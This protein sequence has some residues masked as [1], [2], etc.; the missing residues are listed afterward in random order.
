MAIRRASQE[1]MNAEE[2]VAMTKVSSK[3][4]ESGQ[5]Q[6]IERKLVAPAVHLATRTSPAKAAPEPARTKKS[7]KKQAKKPAA[8]EASEEDMTPYFHG[9]IPKKDAETLLLANG[10]GEVTGRYLIRAKGDGKKEFILSVVYKGKPTHHNVS[11]LASGN[12]SINKKESKAKTLAALTKILAKKNKALGWPVPLTEGVNGPK[13]AKKPSKGAKAFAVIDID[14]DGNLQL[15]EMLQ[16]G[17]SEKTFRLIDT[18]GSGTIEK[19]EFRKWYKA[20]PAEA[21][22]LMKSGAVKHL[23]SS[24]FEAQEELT[25]T[26]KKSFI[27]TTRAPSTL[28]PNFDTDAQELQRTM[29]NQTEAFDVRKTWSNVLNSASSGIPTVG[30]DAQDI[31]RSKHASARSFEAKKQWSNVLY[32]T[33]GETP[34]IDTTAMDFQ[35]AQGSQRDTADYRRVNVQIARGSSVARS[36]G[37]DVHH[38]TAAEPPIDLLIP[39]DSGIMEAQKAKFT[40]AGQTYVKPDSALPPPAVSL[41]ERVASLNFGDT[42]AAGGSVLA[43]RQ[44]PPRRKLIGGVPERPKSAVGLPAFHGKITKKEAEKLLLEDGGAQKQGKYL[45]RAG[46]NDITILSVIFKGKATHHNIK[47]T[48]EGNLKLNKKVTGVSDMI[49]LITLLGSKQKAISWPLALTDGVTPAKAKVGSKQSRAFAIID[50]DGDGQLGLEEM[51]SIGMSQ[52]T[53]H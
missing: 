19:K 20:N 17:M 36:G 13:P 12:F 48:P 10:G 38:S 47:P 35:R 4:N 22:A 26:R 42:A 50:I 30:N 6:A 27:D 16:I 45:L 29:H 43:P 37:A 1:K 18:D 23:K 32:A 52:Q 24:L 25:R 49:E 11:L 14:G 5:F 34:Q 40:A 7:S 9:P 8:A 41:T 53:F 2:P 31:R 51:L 21:K 44:A 15:D 46:D 3:R 33:A 39:P 28:Q